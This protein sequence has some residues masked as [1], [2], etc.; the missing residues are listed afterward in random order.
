VR[1]AAF[2]V[3][4]A[5]FYLSIGA[6]EV[7]PLAWLAPVPL[8]V[9]ALRARS[10]REIAIA[11]G[12][13]AAA[14]AAGLANV[15]VTYRGI[16][17]IAA[18]APIL[19][20]VGIAYGAAV[21]WF[22]VLAR[23]SPPAAVVAFAA[24]WTAL[25]WALSLASPHGTAGS[26]AI[27]QGNVPWIAHAAAYGG[28]YAITFALCVVPAAL[29][30]ALDR[31]RL[32][33]LAT[34]LG[35]FAGLAVAWLVDGPTATATRRVAAIASDRHADATFAD[36]RDAALAPLGDYAPAV[37]AAARAGATLVVLPE[38]MIASRPA[39]RGELDAQ[40]SAL[41]RDNA[42]DLVVGYAEDTR[43]VAVVYRARSA[44]LVY[45]KRHLIPGF[46]SEFEPGT[47]S[48][49][50]DGVAVAICKDL[51]F[52]DTA[53]TNAGAQILAAPAWDFG[54]DAEL[55]RRMAVMRAV[56]GGFALVRAA[57]DGYASIHDPWG[58]VVA[59]QA[60]ADAGVAIAVADVPLGHATL[61]ASTAFGIAML[62]LGLAS[63]A[64][65]LRRRR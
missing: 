9:V 43:N 7:W 41:A 59:E 45:A 51:D 2:A 19:A 27:S 21:A 37:A 62:V 60:T 64:V 53:V 57:R 48:L 34:A 49:A 12:G 22:A 40:F 23:R 58:R 35:V 17:P 10:R 38:K 6:G 46:E 8:L 14:M 47:E 50:F 5:L 55:H 63:S 56:E 13:A 31:R 29:A 15:V 26:I 20:V 24:T 42:V 4:G 44:R 16:L 36:T 28:Q 33:A 39:W 11:G 18:L 3:A 1:P 30:V 65:A 32:W 61:D 54:R 52:Q 25:E